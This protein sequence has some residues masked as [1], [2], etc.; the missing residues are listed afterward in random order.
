MR[1]YELFVDGAWV[2]G[3]GDEEITVLNPATEETIGRVPQATTKDVVAAIEAARRA[4]DEGPWGRS[5]PTERSRFLQRFHESLVARK[6]ELVNLVVQEAGSAQMLADFLQ[7]QTPLDHLAWW[8]ERAAT[9]PYI[10]PM[11][12][13]V[14]LLGLGQGAIHKEPVGVVGAITPFNFP[15]FLNLWKLGPA[16]AMGNT[17]VLKPSP[18]T[19]LEAFVLGEVLAEL[20][21]PP[22]VV[23]IV[24]GDIAAGEEL[25]T[26]PAVDLVSFTG[27]DVVG[28]SVMGQASGTLKKTLL[29]LGGKSANIVFEGVNLD[30]VASGAVM[31]FTTHCGQGCA[32]TT[33]ILVQRRIHDELVEKMK[34]FLEFL[35]VGDPADP[36][37]LMGPLIRES[38]RERVEG[39]VQIALEEGAELA[40]GGGRPAAL[41]RG[42]FVEPTLLTG[43]E[44]SMRIAQEEVF[45]PVGVVIPFD[46]ADDA[47]R[48]ANDSR[49]GLGGGVWHP[50]PAQ[51]YEV[52]KRLR[53]GMVQVNGGGGALINQFG[54]FGGYKQ[55]GVGRE[56]SDHGLQEYCELK[57]IAWPAGR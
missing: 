2:P 18:Y 17:V 33:R 25:T 49:F 52:A 29:E 50:D 26:N 39:Y 9:F 57:T 5:T 31:G 6:D 4:F 22:G 15:I 41:D 3:T 11:P 12:P 34:T 28:R 16:L 14:G 47:V 27:S 56:L 40:F 37:N 42:Y 44:N 24:T 32:L 10:E 36:A 20:D 53:T 43:V 21:L 13:S 55:S 8:A 38:Q 30:D 46:D 7:V 51:A 54:T 45:G 19:P 1:T 48:L 35:P 23:N